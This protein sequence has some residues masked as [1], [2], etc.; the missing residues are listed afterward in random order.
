MRVRVDHYVELDVEVIGEAHGALHLRA[1]RAGS[2]VPVP[3]Q[4]V[5]VQ[6]EDHG[7]W[8]KAQPATISTG[9]D[10]V[11]EITVADAIRANPA[12]A[13]RLTG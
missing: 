9:A 11:L 10:G 5:H 1:H 6:F 3:T 12:A 13:D 8:S 2:T 7:R 4:P